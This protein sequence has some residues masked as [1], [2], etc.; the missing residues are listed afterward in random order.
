MAHYH[1]SP[2]TARP[3]HLRVLA[4]LEAH[5]AT[6]YTDIWLPDW[7]PG[8]Y[9]LGNFAR[10]V[11]GLEVRNSDGE[12]LQYT[13]INRSCWRV[14][15]PKNSR[16]HFHY[17]YFA[18]QA[19]G[20]SCY[21]DEQLFYVNPVHCCV[22]TEHSRGQAC[23]V[24]LELEADF[25][26][27]TGM[28]RTDGLYHTVDFDEL[29]DMPI[30]ASRQ[31]Q[32]D[33]FLHDGVRYHL[34]F[35]GAG[36]VPFDQLKRDFEAFTAAQIRTMGALPV[37]EYHYLNLILPYAWYHG[38]EHRNS[39]V[40]ALGPTENA[41]KGLYTELLGVSSHELFHTWNVKFIQPEAFAPYDYQNENYSQLGYVY[42]GFTTYYG[43]LFLL[44]GGVFDW[45]AY[46]EEVDVYLKR[47][48]DNYGR[49]NHSLHESS[50][51]TWVDGYGGPA[52]PH[53]RVSIYAEGMLNALCLDM[54]M[55]RCTDNEHSLDTLMRRLYADAVNGLPYDEVRLLELLFE[56]TDC[57]FEAFFQQHYQQP[58]S[59]ETALPAALAQVGCTLRCTVSENPLERNYGIRV[60]AG[61][62]HGIVAMVAPGS[63]AA[64]CGLVADDQ[65]LA[66]QL[67][68]DQLHIRW[69]DKMLHEHQ[70]VLS[71][72]D[73]RWFD[74]YKLERLPNPTPAQDE[75]FAR[76]TR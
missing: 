35:H 30:L 58:I 19:D 25:E 59:L 57:S 76:W 55:R 71:A 49:Y 9:E 16:I 41:F 40:I 65:L 73:G 50:I 12:P 66:Q 42:E 14:H 60:K 44:R 31:L 69:K 13:K 34:W 17:S 3:R 7:R 6:N 70:A 39:T 1:L 29:V 22:Y 74:I 10:N 20:G 43:D 18:N 38:V 48:F 47:H 56:I 64:H 54:E 63:P 51:D 53:R 8:R 75:A 61:G 32:H 62:E 15:A 26:V 67:E 21:V 33:S 27:A 37:Q 11:V 68:D 24:L 46:A 5:P 4:M 36:Q 72:G 23:S 45:Q 52:A 28:L 2:D